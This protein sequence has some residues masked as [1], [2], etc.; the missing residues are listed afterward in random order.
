MA[1]ELFDG[2]TGA[3]LARTEEGCEICGIADAGNL[4]SSAAATLRTA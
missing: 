2:G 1:V 3:S 4:I